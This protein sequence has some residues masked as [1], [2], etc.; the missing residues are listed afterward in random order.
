MHP[1]HYILILL[2]LPL[3]CGMSSSSLALDATPAAPVFELGGKQPLIAEWLLAQPFSIPTPQGADPRKP[4]PSPRNV[5]FLQSIG[6]ETK[7]RPVVGTKVEWHG[8]SCEFLPVKDAA[9]IESVAK[10][11]KDPEAA[12]SIMHYCTYA[13]TTVHAAAKTRAYLF[14]R[15][16]QFCKVWVNG[17]IVCPPEGEKASTDWVKIFAVELTQGDN[18]LLMKR[19]VIRNKGDIYVR[20][21]DE[22]GARAILEK[23]ASG[24]L[25]V[26][27][28]DAKAAGPVKI[29]VDIEPVCDI[30]ASV[31]AEVKAVDSAGKTIASGSA[32]LGGECEFTLPKG[33]FRVQARVAEFGGRELT[34]KADLFV[35]SE[36]RAGLEAIVARAREA[37]KAGGLEDF[38][39]LIEMG[40]TKVEDL[41]RLNLPDLPMTREHAFDLDK[42]TQDA[43]RDSRALQAKRGWIE[44]AYRS[45]ADG[46]GQPFSLWIPKNYDPQ[47][48]Y[49]LEI[50]LHGA[51]GDHKVGLGA[52]DGPDS[53]DARF[54]GR[55]PQTWYEGLAEVDILEA[56]DF[57]VGHWNID[58]NRIHLHGAS[59]GGAETFKL[60]SRHPDLFASARP[61]CGGGLFLPIENILNLPMFSV[62]SDDDPLMSVGGSRAPLDRLARAGGLV[63]K[64]ETTGLGHEA[65]GWREGVEKAREWALQQV[66]SETPRRVRYTATD[67]AASGAYWVKIVEWGPEGRPATID[68]RFG[69]DNTLYVNLDNVSLARID[70]AA[71]PANLKHAAAVVVNSQM[72]LSVSAPLPS[73]LYLFQ[74]NGK[75]KAVAEPPAAP[76]ERYHFPGGAMALYNGEPLMIAYGTQ[77]DEKTNGILRGAAEAAS[78]SHCSAW[79]GPVE[80]PTGWPGGWMLYGRIPVKSDREVTDEDMRQNNLLLLGS[81]GQNSIVAKIADRLPV[82]I[83]HGRAVSNDGISWD[84]KGRALGLLHF[85]PLAPK[86][87]IYWVAADSPEFREAGAAVME[88]QHSVAPPDFLLLD[89]KDSRTVAARRFDSRWRFEAGYGDS[90]FLPAAANSPLAFSAMLGEATRRAC[91]A[92]F[93]LVGQARDQKPSF[94]PGETRLMDFATLHFQTRACVV[95]VAGKRMLAL[96]KGIE[97]REGMTGEMRQ[98]IPALVPASIEPQQIYRIAMPDVGWLFA[99]IVHDQIPI[100]ETD[101]MLRDAVQRGLLSGAAAAAAAAPKPPVKAKEARAGA[102]RSA[103]R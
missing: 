25:K 39:G 15:W 23:E 66:R 100:E 48:A 62:H 77:A 11:L 10:F 47:R 33:F 40:A 31:K 21:A 41:L 84:F 102:G 65:W 51:G 49:P 92:D 75:W 8:Q 16:P 81:A 73:Q 17:Q 64:A 19:S 13:Y 29:G 2:A 57:I 96:T 54:L 50:N 44:W 12:R 78:H 46:S 87:L 45:K 85:N 93:A 28:S 80:K 22:A 30:F 20:L 72:P 32:P 42:N 5:D 69:E 71:S 36:P 53:F 98:F 94:I 67:E 14:I 1:C 91:G 70:L 18:A 55:G 89:A 37:Q 38:A 56:I 82:K 63:V 3:F 97:Q 27:A 76:V 103:G 61:E 43:A 4:A 59:M 101:V 26:V 83:D 74:E 6:G 35:A 90:P 68:A 88:Q 52:S 9:G 86:R 95:E 99:L 34:G 58:R 79:P 24:E 7:A 60:A